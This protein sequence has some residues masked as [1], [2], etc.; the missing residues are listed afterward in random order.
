[1][2]VDADFTVAGITFS[3]HG[4]RA[5]LSAQRTLVRLPAYSDP[6][7]SWKNAV[8]LP[9]EVSEALADTVPAFLVEHG[10]ARARPS[11]P[12]R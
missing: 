8:T 3:I 10:V 5:S 11:V 4:V 1:M 12:A 6:A 7:G 9:P 2:L